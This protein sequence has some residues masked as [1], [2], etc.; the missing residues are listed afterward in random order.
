MTTTSTRPFRFSS[1]WP[2][3][4]TRFE[5]V[6]AEE[7]IGGPLRSERRQSLPWLGIASAISASVYLIFFQVGADW[8]S[9]VQAAPQPAAVSQAES[10]SGSQEQSEPALASTNIAPIITNAPTPSVTVEV[11]AP[12]PTSEPSEQPE[13]NSEQQAEAPPVAPLPPPVVNKDDPYQV[14]ALA[15]GLHPGLSRALLVRLTKTDFKNAAHAIRTALAKTPDDK[16]FVWPRGRSTKVTRFQVRF[17]PK[18]IAALPTLHC[19]GDPGRLG[20]DRAGDGKMWAEADYPGR[21]RPTWQLDSLSPCSTDSGNCPPP[22]VISL[23]LWQA[24]ICHAALA[25]TFNL[26]VLS[27][28]LASVLAV[29]W[30]ATLTVRPVR[31][32]CLRLC[33]AE[34]AT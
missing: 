14:R 4:D 29:S 8:R 28:S 18:H 23:R 16:V 6:Y 7:R 31:A 2:D 1:D 34:V 10:Q 27:S 33:V 19:R 21:Q 11:A 17:V 20:D 12:E 25:T 30:S 5:S 13:Q 9:P 22:A 24:R 15:A 32:R 3:S 26:F